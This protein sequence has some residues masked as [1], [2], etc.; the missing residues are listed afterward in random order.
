MEDYGYPPE[1]PAEEEAN[2][3]KEV[4]TSSEPVIKDKSKSKKVRKKSWFYLSGRFT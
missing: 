3:P 2:E 1:F 4:E